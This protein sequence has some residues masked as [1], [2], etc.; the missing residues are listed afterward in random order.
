MAG[1]TGRRSDGNEE[2]SEGEGRRKEGAERDAS[3]APG[4]RPGRGA[5]TSTKN[6]SWQ[7]CGASSDPKNGSWQVCRCA[8]RGGVSYSDTRHHGETALRWGS[9]FGRSA[10]IEGQTLQA[11]GPHWRY[12]D[13][14]VVT[15]RSQLG[16]PREQQSGRWGCRRWWRWD[17]DRVG[18]DEVPVA[19]VGGV[20]GVVADKR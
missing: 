11:S 7:V 12:G 9:D 13:L 8:A 16:A 17:A 2:G 5:S 6:G 10:V 14:G 3:T 4:L 20:V 15:R 18:G 19:A 1:R